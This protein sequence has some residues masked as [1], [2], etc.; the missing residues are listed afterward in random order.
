MKE[1]FG[2]EAEPVTLYLYEN[3]RAFARG[4]IEAG[5]LAPAVAEATAQYAC[6][7]STQGKILVNAAELRHAPWPDRLRLLAHELTHVAQF[8]LSGGR[9]G[10]SDQWLRE[11][12]AD[13]VSFQLVDRLGL[14]EYARLRQ[15]VAAQLRRARRRQ[16]LPSLADLTA[17]QQ[18]DAM[19]AQHGET[20]TYGV[21]FFAVEHLLKARAPEAMATYFRLFARSQDRLANFRVAFGIA[22]DDFA[23]A[24]RDALEQLAIVPEEPRHDNEDYRTASQP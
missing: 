17:F 10:T 15:E 5:D 3:R 12:Y 19:R 14:D 16:P 20:V 18:W 11:G 9:R 1:A 8:A 7:I 21:A 24:F 22:F 13:W 2:L 4:L 6:A 23:R